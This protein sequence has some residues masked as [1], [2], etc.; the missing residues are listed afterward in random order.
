MVLCPSL[1]GTLCSWVPGTLNH[2]CILMSG[3]P[4][5]GGR[6]PVC[7]E[8]G[9]GPTDWCGLTLWLRCE[10]FTQVKG[11]EA[12]LS[13]GMPS[14][15]ATRVSP[16]SGRRGACP[17]QR[18]H[19]SAPTAWSCARSCLPPSGG[20]RTGPS[21]RKRRLR[22]GKSQQP[23]PRQ[24]WAPSRPRPVPS[25]GSSSCLCPCCLQVHGVLPD[26]LQHHVRFL[27]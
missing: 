3:F 1:K 19:K 9:A 25:P 13:K 14:V 7:P 20:V 2:A 4:A 8:P 5:G 16:R 12:W 27:L 21:R 15:A 22:V 26:P 17:G 6:I 11:G 18:S 23:F 24:P 10:G